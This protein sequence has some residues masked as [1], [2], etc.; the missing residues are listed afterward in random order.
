MAKAPPFEQALANVIKE[1]I[2]IAN[3]ELSDGKITITQYHQI[4]ADNTIFDKQANLY[5]FYDTDSDQFLAID[6]DTKETYTV[7]IPTGGIDESRTAK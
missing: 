4:Y 5:F 3:Q 7:K 2:K 6:P 1:R